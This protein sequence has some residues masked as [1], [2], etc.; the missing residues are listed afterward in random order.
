VIL[1]DAELLVDGK[2]IE[3]NE[4][5]V[6]VLSGIIGGV[7]ASLRGIDKNWKEIEIKVTK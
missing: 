3:L 1:L 7:V 6:K 4:F 2:K 5:V